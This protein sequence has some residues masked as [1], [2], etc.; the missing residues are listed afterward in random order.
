MKEILKLKSS[1]NKLRLAIQFATN[2]FIW[3]SVFK[4]FPSASRISAFM[5]EGV[6]CYANYKS[7]LII[8]YTFEAKASAFAV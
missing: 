8:K 2:D 5:V 7:P 1:N 6:A 3:Y 4:K